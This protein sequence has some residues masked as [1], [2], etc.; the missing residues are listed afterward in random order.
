MKK[1]QWFVL[2]LVL[3]LCISLFACTS[4][5]EFGIREKSD[6][7]MV[8]LH[9]GPMGLSYTLTNAI[10]LKGEEESEFVCTT[11]SQDQVKEGAFL[12]DSFSDGNTSVTVAS[13]T[14]IYWFCNPFAVS[15][16]TWLEF[17]NQKNSQ[18]IGYAVVKVETNVDQGF[19]KAE[20][21]KAVTFPKI[22]GK[23]QT[24]TEEQ[25]NQLI[26]DVIG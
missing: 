22:G 7:N 5:N 16:V 13:E 25:V 3:S 23:Y 26:D 21:V 6:K 17:I 2:F 11:S 19:Y 14:T 20:V 4:A 12:L 1:R 9:F 24:V 10:T 8:E 15:E 18:I